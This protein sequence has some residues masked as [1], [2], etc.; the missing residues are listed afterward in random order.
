MLTALNIRDFILID[1]AQLTL[2]HGLAALTG[3]TGA[4]KSILLDALGLAVGGRATRSGVRQGASQG[5]VAATFEV[6]G[7]HPVW[8]LLDENGL[9]G[10]DGAGED[11]Q[12][13]LRRVQ[14]ADGRS[15]GFV[16]DQPVSISMLRDV[17]EAL[18]EIHGQHDGRGFLSASAH[19]G[20]LD[21]FGGLQKK[22]AK[23]SSLWRAWREAQSA[24]EERRREQDAA[25]REAEYLRHVYDVLQKLGP[26]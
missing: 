21:E 13:I 1:R 8:R 19:R 22:A 26:Q 15:R 4:G 11:G 23:I 17:G 12:I 7:D 14:N 2:T 10:E 5:V 25:A 18:L 9:A 6:D 3:E 20:M 16:N 24:L